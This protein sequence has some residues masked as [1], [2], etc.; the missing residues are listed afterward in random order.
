MQDNILFP[1]HNYNYLSGLTVL[2]PYSRT[3]LQ[4][5][6][7]MHTHFLEVFLTKK[8]P[9]NYSLKYVVIETSDNDSFKYFDI[10]T[11]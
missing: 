11:S 4:S 5:F 8:L 9:K 3:V 6:A 2:Q 1:N 7:H 10:E